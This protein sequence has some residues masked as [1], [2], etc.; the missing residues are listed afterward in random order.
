MVY[1]VYCDHHE[2]EAQLESTVGPEEL[3]VRA[4][5]LGWSINRY[6]L[7]EMNEH[8]CPAHKSN[9]VQGSWHKVEPSQVREAVLASLPEDG[10][11][12]T[13]SQVYAE[14]LKT[15]PSTQKATVSGYLAEQA[16]DRRSPV[17][18]VA[19]GVYRRKS[20]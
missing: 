12:M 11:T 3:E 1:V 10:S 9:G 14:V 17:E 15:V 18:R 7:V 4:E 8:Y 2:C 16:R 20:K 5:N 6:A 19:N 13:N